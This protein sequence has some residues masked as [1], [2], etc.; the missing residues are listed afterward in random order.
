MPTLRQLEYLVAVAETLHFR[1]AAEKVHG[2]QSTLSLQIK[3]LEDRLG[4]QLVERSRTRVVMT[5]IGNEVVAIARK[6]LRD[7]K[8]IRDLAAVDRKDF[9]GV[10]RLGLPHTKAPYFLP[11]VV[12]DLRRAY[13]DLK[14]RIYED[15][16]LA[17]T[18]G[19]RD[20]V[21]DIIIVPMP[22]VAEDLHSVPLYREPLYVAVAADHPLARQ[23]RIHRSALK[24]QSVLA[25]GP[26]HQLHELVLALCEE[27]GA[28]VLTD[29][30]GTSLNTLREMVAMGVGITFFPGLYVR[31]VLVQH[32]TIKTI[33]LT[34]RQVYRTVGMAWRK[35]SA[36]HAHYEQIAKLFA[37]VI[38]RDFSDFA[39][40]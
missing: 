23:D 34:G 14:L 17:L 30:E 10:V 22:V 32:K 2:T 9:T 31:T 40:A 15:L 39:I 19:L 25:L 4:V 13:P 29:Y 33:E 35:S 18:A 16:P 37:S 36:R 21:H 7:V 24:G 12:P 1:R 28:K 3:A 6:V 38:E 20:G 27:F 11:R 8:D 5:P 26:G